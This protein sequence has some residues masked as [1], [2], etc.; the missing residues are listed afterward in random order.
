MAINLTKG[1]KVN[2]AKGQTK[3]RI[4]LSWD[5]SQVPG[6]EFDLDAMALE[7]DAKNPPHKCISE[8]H[9]VFY[10]NL[11]DPEKA[12]THSGDNRTGEGDGDDETII[13]DVTKLNP[14][15]KKVLVVMNIHEGMNRGQNFG[16]VRN[17]KARLYYGDSDVAELVYDL[18]E[19]ASMNTQIEFC[20]IYE[21]NGEWK[22]EAIGQGAKATLTSLLQKYGLDAGPNNI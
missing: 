13:V 5:A 16:Q 21:H 3:F 22:F 2:L 17:A 18:E 7:L 9:F 12:V 20:S 4:G 6:T 15:T 14:S 10:G 1:E 19:D 11:Q 8:K